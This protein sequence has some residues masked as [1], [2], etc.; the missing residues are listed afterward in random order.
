MGVGCSGG[1]TGG[2]RAQR[3]MSPSSPPS[4]RPSYV[5][6]DWDPDCNGCSS[7][8]GSHFAWGVGG[9]GCERHGPR[10]EWPVPPAPQSSVH[11]ALGFRRWGVVLGWGDGRPSGSRP[12]SPSSL[13]SPHPSDIAFNRDPFCAGSLSRASSEFTGES[14]GK[15]SERHGVGASSPSP[16]APQSKPTCS[17]VCQTPSQSSSRAGLGA[18]TPANA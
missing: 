9:M 3:P 15:G 10:S 6:V 11:F 14:R 18:E 5:V 13:P 1:V 12:M 2:H 17:T 4:P 7:R 8:A 16:S